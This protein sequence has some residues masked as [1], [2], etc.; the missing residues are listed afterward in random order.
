M[1]MVALPRRGDPSSVSPA[2]H[3]QRCRFVSRRLFERQR[4]LGRLLAPIWSIS[5]IRASDL[6]LSSTLRMISPRLK[7]TPCPCPP[8]CPGRPRAPR[9][10]VYD[11]AQHAHLDRRLAV[12]HARVRSFMI[13]V[14]SISRRPQVGQAISSGLR[15]RRPVAWGMSKAARSHPLVGHRLTRIVSPIAVDQQRRQCR[16]RL[17]M[18]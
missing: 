17:T 18:A 13:F 15:T 3:R 16:P 8:R 7:I 4:P 14:R 12:A 9:R 6:S 1:D 5:S 2:H 10:A 11:A